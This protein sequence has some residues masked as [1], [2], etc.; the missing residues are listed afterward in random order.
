M[1]CTHHLS[2]ERIR[3][4]L[5]ILFLT[6]ITNSSFGQQSTL[7][8]KKDTVVVESDD[9]YAVTTNKFWDNWFIGAGAGAQIY[10]SDHNR[11]M[12]FGD[13][14]SPAYQFN[15]GKWFTPGIGV[16]AGVSG[17]T[18][19]GVTQNKS[20]STGEI[21]DASKSLEKQEFD[22]YH[23]HGDV[24]FN[25]TNIFAGYKENRFYSIS[26][27]AGLGW[28]QVV[29]DPKAKEVSANVGLYNAFRL[30]RAVDLTLDFRG[31]LVNDRLD[32]EEGGRM[33][34]G[35]LSTTLGLVYKFN[36]REWRRP[37]TTTISYDEAA[38]NAIQNR[39]NT[40]ETDNETLRKQLAD[41]KTKTVTDVKVENRILAAPILVTFP[42]NKSTVSNEARVNL[43]FFAKV[44]NEGSS[45]VVYK[46]TGYADKGTGTPRIND[47]LSK[48]RAEAIYKVLVKEFGVSESQLEVS[49]EGGVDNMFYNDPRLSRAVIT[50]AK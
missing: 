17:L 49:H 33:Q 47:R 22:F 5:G 19:Y 2:T 12:K 25:L 15:I 43:G 42:I 45:S 35:L 44:I 48:A 34:E 27:Y 36:K 21:Y 30:G 18:V 32:G 23:L 37:S 9:R 28:M 46:V 11:Q 14:L 8:L 24:L 26:P 3:L 6:A 41:A 20:H 13:R 1:L 39:I 29:D 40:L 31:S 38:L 4:F 7:N 10:F 50:I 16:R